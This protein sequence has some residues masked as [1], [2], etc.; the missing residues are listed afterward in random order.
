MGRALAERYAAL[1]SE[2]VGVDVRADAAH[3]VVAGNTAEAGEWQ[4]LVNGCDLVIHTAAIVS[5]GGDADRFW[6]VN[7]LG[8]RNALDAAARAGVARFIHISSVTAFGFRFPDMVDEQ[9]PVR[10]NGSPYVDTKVTGEQVVLQAHAAGELACTVIRPGD[11]YGPASRVWTVI[12]V[13]MIR[14]GSFALP[15]RGRGVFSPTYIDNLVDG[16]VLAASRPEAAGQVFTLTDGV[17]T[18]T[19]EFFG[20]YARWLGKRLR[21]LPAPVLRQVATVVSSVSRAARRDSELN[22]HTIDYLSRTGT[23]SIAKAQRVLGY[24]ARVQLDEGMA[25]TEAWLRSSGRLA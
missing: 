13:E 2:V 14:R 19:A 25:R 4:N 11:V 15:M 9:Y 22:V 20:H 6:R 24:S 10:V 5:L 1:G 12:P 3:G 17:G 16:I 7:V 21:L 18:T 23:Y 8:T